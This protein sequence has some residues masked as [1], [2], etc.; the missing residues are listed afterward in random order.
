MT[1]KKWEM[2]EQVSKDAEK[3]LL[4]CYGIDPEKKESFFNPV[5][6]ESLRGPFEILNMDK[7][8]E[9]ILRAIKNGEKILLYGDYDADGI[10]GTIVFHDFLKK[11]GYSNFEAYIPDRHKDGYGLTVEAMEGFKK[12]GIDLIITIDC[13]VTDVEEIKKANELGI[14]TIVTDHH[15]QGEE[16]PPAVAVVD[17]KQEKDP[18]PFKMLCGAAV[19]FKVVN[20][21]IEKGGFN[22]VE[23]WTK[24]L[25]D[26]VCIATIA[27]M[28]PLADE[29]R[30]I[31]FYGLQ[32]LR[33]TRRPG[34]LALFKKIKVNKK[35]IKED[36][37]AFYIAPRINTA[38]RM[39]R[40]GISF[41]LLSTESKEEAEWAAERLDQKND[42]RR[43]LVE[44]IVNDVDRMIA[45]NPG[46]VEIF[47]LGDEKW[48]AGVL[49]IAANRVLEK[50]NKPVV[51]WGKGEEGKYIKGS[52]RANGSLNFVELMDF[53][54][55][56]FFTDRGGH[57]LSAGF[58]VKEEKV[59]ELSEAFGEAIKKIQPKEAENAIMVDK[60]ATIEEIDWEFLR[61]VEKFEPFGMG[62]PKP[63]FLIKNLEVF[64][65]KM[66]GNGGIH[67]QVDFKRNPSTGSGQA[68]KIL[69][70]IAFFM[71]NE[72]VFEIKK[73]DKI[74]LLASIE[75]STFKG[76]DELRL[77]IVDFKVL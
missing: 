65:V 44:G 30:T 73:G 25:L 56:E 36:D 59:K 60:E 51:L 74:D 24:W 54:G 48:E 77:K 38:G 37:V 69:S 2:K 12:Q 10:C 53:L 31:V 11:I 19:A 9:R 40:A 52:A 15:F 49:G 18:Y 58:T 20:A 21:L 39:G 4:H 13:G 16:L 27:D 50:Y 75:R 43:E 22:I 63:V 26:V 47:C 8:V 55:D 35:N 67:L 32:V 28:M 71:K 7:A 14:D 70:A 34:L 72:G 64:G 33:K 61:V 45:E 23:G 68:G 46:D 76:Y 41:E 42:E 5:Y 3:Q 1:A 29:N 6:E 57:A 17:P 62:N 66:F